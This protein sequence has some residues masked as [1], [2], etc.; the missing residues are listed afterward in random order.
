M[1][2]NHEVIQLCNLYSVRQKFGIMGYYFHL[3]RSILFFLS[4][5][6]LRND[7]IFFND[8]L[9]FVHRFG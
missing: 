5:P 4:T 7:I 3:H 2:D 6:F 1:G 9:N 8:K